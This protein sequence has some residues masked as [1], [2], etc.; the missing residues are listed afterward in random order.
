MWGLSFL[1]SNSVGGKG[2]VETVFTDME[3]YEKIV[4]TASSRAFCQLVNN[5]ICWRRYDV[6]WLFVMLEWYVLS[7]Y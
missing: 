1:I 3:I 2:L 4:N 5:D 7:T 6:G